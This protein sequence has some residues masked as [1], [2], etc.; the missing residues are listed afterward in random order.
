MRSY[1]RTIESRYIEPG[2]VKVSDKQSDAIAYLYASRRNGKPGLQVFFGKQ[3]K[4]VIWSWYSTKEARNS[5]LR[6][7]F[8]GRRKSIAFKQERKGA[9]KNFVH[10][11]KVGDVYY[12]SWGYDQ[13][14]VEF[15]QIVEIHGKFAIL[16]ELS[17]ASETTGWETG[18]CSAKKDF[19]AQPRYEGDDRGQPIRRLI[20]D[21]H[22][23]IDEVRYAWPDKG[24][25]HR[26]SSYA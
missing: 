23:K 1:H 20:Q 18:N 26:W 5:A 16:R 9:R 15:F 12:T 3:S 11:A 19:F 8:E 14:N 2:S 4:P 22:I 17:Q 13:T 24:G 21:G 25:K 6:Q 7:Y 10:N